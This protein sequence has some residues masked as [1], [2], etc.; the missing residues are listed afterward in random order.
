MTFND[1][2]MDWKSTF[3]VNLTTIGLSM[4]AIDVGLKY[5]AMIVGIVWTKIQII[6]GNYTIIDRN[7]RIRRAYKIYKK[8]KKKDMNIVNQNRE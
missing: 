3:L 6:N 8:K 2:Y 1:L 4:T 5:G 7:K